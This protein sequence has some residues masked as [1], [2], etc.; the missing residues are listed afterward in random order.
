MD[1]ILDV[2]T[3][4]GVFLISLLFCC[5]KNHQVI[6]DSIVGLGTDENSLTRVVVT[7]AEVDMM[8]IRAEYL[9][10]NKTSID[11]DLKGD[12]S[13]DYKNFLLTLVGATL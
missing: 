11:G 4:L 9:N 8:K 6:R 12:T 3:F 1:L 7:R 2:I 13:G 5:L 10:M